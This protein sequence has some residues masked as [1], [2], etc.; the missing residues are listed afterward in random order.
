MKP[1]FKIG[2]SV[3]S[4]KEAE[5]AGK[6]KQIM[7]VAVDHLGVDYFGGRFFDGTYRCIWID[8]TGQK[9]TKVYS[10]NDLSMSNARILARV[11]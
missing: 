2:D 7:T 8:E 1:K 6:G 10:E 11:N 5:T 4:R 9:K 3:F